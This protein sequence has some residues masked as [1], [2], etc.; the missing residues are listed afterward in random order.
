MEMPAMGF[1][2]KLRWELIE[3]EGEWM[4]LGYCTLNGS[5]AV[6]EIH[7]LVENEGIV[8]RVRSYCFCPETLGVVAEQLGRALVRRPITHRSP[9]MADV[10]RLLLRHIMTRQS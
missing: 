9:S 1:G 6:N 8:T 3:F 5:E 4:V 10:P 2:R 7:R